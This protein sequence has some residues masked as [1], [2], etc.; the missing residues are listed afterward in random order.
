MNSKLVRM[1]LREKIRDKNGKQISMPE[2][3]LETHFF[4]MKKKTLLIILYCLYHEML[5]EYFIPKD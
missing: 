5:K 3:I 1:L 4:I 2:I